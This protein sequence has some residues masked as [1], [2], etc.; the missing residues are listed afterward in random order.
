[1]DNRFLKKSKDEI[2]NSILE[3]LNDKGFLTNE[4]SMCRLFTSIYSDVLYNIYGYIEKRHLNCFVSTADREHLEKLA[5]N[6]GL[7]FEKEI[8]DTK[9]RYLI[10]NHVMLNNSTSRAVV[11]EVILREFK[12]VFDVRFKSFIKGA[13]S[14]GIYIYTKEESS[15]LLEDITR[16]VRRHLPAGAYIFIGYPEK[17]EVTFRIKVVSN[18]RTLSEEIRLRGKIVNILG[19]VLR[20]DVFSSHDILRAITSCDAAITNSY[21]LETLIDGKSEVISVLS[22]TPDSCY[23]LSSKTEIVF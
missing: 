11:K 21:I 23:I 16:R 10:T 22:T 3:K 19:E 13:G 17:R 12:D 1:M 14:E 18:T 15:S 9:L 6:V 7:T 4:G 5:F 8:T 20:R 2:E